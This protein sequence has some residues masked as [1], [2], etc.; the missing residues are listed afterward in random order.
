MAEI[1][2]DMK[3][4]TREELNER[5]TDEIAWRKKELSILRE[6]IDSLRT[7]PIK[8]KALIRCGVP[9]LYAH[10]E[11]FV[12]IAATTYLCYIAGKRHNYNELS[13]SF[14]ALSMKAKMALA[15]ETRRATIFIPIAEFFI[16]GLSER[17]IIPYEDAI[18][19]QGNLS[20]RVFK[21]I[22]RILSLEYSDYELKDKFIDE[23]ILRR[24]N[25][26][27][28]GRDDIIDYNEYVSVHN[29]VIALMDAFK[30]QIENAALLKNY[31]RR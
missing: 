3:I 13:T 31:L 9:I 22:V 5:L 21:D 24:R 16:R 25:M 20:S 23:K 28:H 27:A 7:A 1:C 10:W 30:T 11:G 19:T 2:L 26:I 12:K 4:R 18:S 6:T 17:A 8:Q 15:A 29:E 14:V